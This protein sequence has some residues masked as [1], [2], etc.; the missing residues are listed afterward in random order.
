MD[1]DE[2]GALAT[3]PSV[4]LVV[5]ARLLGPMAV[6]R[7]GVALDAMLA[8]AVALRD[9]LPPPPPIVRIEI[10]VEREPGGRFHLCSFATPRFDEYENRYINRRF[11]VEQAQAM[12]SAKVRTLRITAGPAKSYR[13]PLEAGHVEADT[14]V[15]Y[16]VGR[17][18]EVRELLA[19]VSHVGKKRSV[20]L[21]KVR[22]WEVEVLAPADTWPGFPVLRDGLPLRPL[23]PDWAGLSDACDLRL[24]NVTYP[25]WLHTERTICAMPGAVE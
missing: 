15:W 16:C 14:L 23:P 8:A 17:D 10:P 1:G 22:A 7:S 18:D 5:T 20:G 12:G 19:L 4:P 11:P 21:G 2:T 9:G 25:Y 6:P 3:A 13:I 24:F